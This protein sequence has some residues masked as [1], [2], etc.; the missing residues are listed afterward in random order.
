MEFETW[1]PIYREI[2]A[3]FG[4]DEQSDRR[5]RDELAALVTPFDLVRIDFSGT[6]VAI[7]GGSKGLVEELDIARSADQCIAVSGAAKVLTDHGIEPDL[8]V[9]DLD[10]TPGTAEQL[11][12]EGVP[13]AIHGHGDNIE[14][15]RSL[16]PGFDLEHVLGTTQVEPVPGVYNFGGFTDG[17][18]AAFL[19]DQF[20][21]ASL[22]FPGWELGDSTVSPAKAKKLVWAGR[23]LRCLELRRSEQ[24]DVLDGRRRAIDETTTVPEWSCDTQP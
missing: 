20:G 3:D 9:T 16:V 7:A 14:T 22:R 21:A 12:K 5:A 23:L 15:L 8:V 10:G 2:G 6:K 24:F 18:R 19:A 1:A 17:D 4:F 11:S 13:V